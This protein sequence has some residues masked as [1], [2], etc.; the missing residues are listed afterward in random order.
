MNFLSIVYL[1]VIG[2]HLIMGSCGHSW[3]H[4]IPQI[5]Y[6]VNNMNNNKYESVHD[7]YDCTVFVW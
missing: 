5:L 3:Q 4:Y 6:T 2:V 7:Q 1:E